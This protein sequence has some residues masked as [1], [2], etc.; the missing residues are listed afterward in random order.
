MV[1]LSAALF[2]YGWLELTTITNE[3]YYAAFTFCGVMGIYNFHRLV[4]M[5]QRSGS[6]WMSWVAEK[7]KW[8]W[9]LVL[10]CFIIGTVLFFTELWNGR[11]N[12]IFLLFAALLLSLWYI[13]PMRGKTLRKLPFFKSPVIALNWVLIICVFPVVNEGVDLV[14]FILPICLIWLF[15]VALTIPFDVRDLQYDGSGNFTIPQFIGRQN[16]MRLGMFLVLLFFSTFG[17][18]FH[19]WNNPFYYLTA[20]VTFLLFLFAPKQLNDNYCALFDLSIGL[21]GLSLLY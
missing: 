4:K 19:Q 10:L 21:L 17:Y 12:V 15:V 20:A 11:Y 6:V 7:S 18:L 16:S 13:I 1:S 3:S 5:S 14:P 9:I 8:L 2:C